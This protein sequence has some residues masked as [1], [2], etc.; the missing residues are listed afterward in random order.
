MTKKERVFKALWKK[1]SEEVLAYIYQYYP[2]NFEEICAKFDT[3]SPS[4]IRKITNRLVRA[5]LIKNKKDKRFDD[6]RARAFVIDD[7]NAV[8]AILELEL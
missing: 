5:H 2:V 1:G 3:L 4:S 8:I 6:K 7:E